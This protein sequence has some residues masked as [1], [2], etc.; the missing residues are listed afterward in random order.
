MVNDTTHHINYL[1]VWAGGGVYEYYN[2]EMRE[3]AA[4]RRPQAGL[5]YV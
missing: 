5:M 4:G 1:G 2:G 3:Q